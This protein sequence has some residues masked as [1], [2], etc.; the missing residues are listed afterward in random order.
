[1][2]ELPEV[3][4][5]RRL[6]ETTL[7]GQRL[8]EVWAAPDPIV[9]PDAGPEELQEILQGRVVQ[10]A[11]RRGKQLWLELDG[12][13]ALLMHFGMSGA[14][15]APEGA[16]VPLH[17][18]PAVEPA[19]WPPR[20]CKL[21]LRAAS[22]ELCFVNKRRLGRLLLREQPE[23]SPPLCKLGFDPLLDPPGPEAFG[24]LLAGR[25]GT[26]KGCLLNQRL[27]AGLG[28]WL[29]DDALHR[30]AIAPRRPAGSLRPA[31]VQALY[32]AILQIVERAVA[33]DAQSSRFPPEWLFHRRWKPQA[34]AVTEDGAPIQF[35]TVAGRTTAWVPSRQR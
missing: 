5:G 19:G 6:A 22:G 13:P 1:M 3:E 25:R 15:V 34:D 20:F 8:L 21:R 4:Y 32:A 16:R 29:V 24:A 2:P 14:L 35:D 7:V 10:A 12:G 33:V 11:R 18:S 28:N 23:R 30:A 9:C 17:S 27:V 26:I 31:E